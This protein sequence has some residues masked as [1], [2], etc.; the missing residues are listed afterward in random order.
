[1]FVLLTCTFTQYPL[2]FYHHQNVHTYKHRNKN[3]S[4]Y[5]LKCHPLHQRHASLIMEEKF[6][7]QGK[8]FSLDK[9]TCYDLNAFTLLQITC[10]K[11]RFRYVPFIDYP[12]EKS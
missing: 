7:R 9:Y 8:L 12:S 6:E 4:K 1:M 2:I 5:T 3:Y 11:Y 10:F